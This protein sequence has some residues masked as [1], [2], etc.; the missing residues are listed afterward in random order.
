MYLLV[1]IVVYLFF[2]GKRFIYVKLFINI[3]FDLFRIFVYIYMFFF[4]RLYSM[5]CGLGYLRFF[6]MCVF[7]LDYLSLIIL[8]F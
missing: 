7:C 1:K 3:F 6:G 5:F 8:I 2:Y 4:Y